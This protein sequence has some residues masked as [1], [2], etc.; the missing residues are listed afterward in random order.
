MDPYSLPVEFSFSE[1]LAKS[2]SSRVFWENGFK[3]VAAVAS[4]DANELV[5][6]LLQVSLIRE[7]GR[8]ERA[9]C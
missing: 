6:V 2:S 4:A 1:Q 8:R 7:D 9:M 5:P 3:S